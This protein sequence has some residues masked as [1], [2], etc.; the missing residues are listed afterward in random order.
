M[1]SSF[2]FSNTALIDAVSFFFFFYYLKAVWANLLHEW[3]LSQLVGGPF[4][5]SLDSLHSDC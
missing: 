1:L 4:N 3:S 5:V 2:S